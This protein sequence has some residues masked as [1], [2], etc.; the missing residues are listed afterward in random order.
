MA[1]SGQSP[2]RA[3]SRNSF[4]Q[5][6]YSVAEL[7]SV[8]FVMALLMS[9]VALIIGPLMRSQSQTQAKVDTVQAADVALYR[10][11][12]DL[13]NTNLSF[14]WSCT[15]TATPVCQAPPATL[16]T[17]SAIVVASAYKNGTGPFQLTSSTG[18]PKWQGATVYW[19]DTKGD[20]E[21]AFDPPS[22]FVPGS[23]MTIV[24]AQRAVSDVTVG[25]GMHLARFVE[26]LSLAVPGV[27]HQ[28]ALQMQ[29]QSTVNGAVN[30][31]T[32]RTDLETRN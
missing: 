25:G 26:T 5:R 7:L 1:A 28:V 22:G 11:E 17:T 21:V 13:R 2:S 29:A 15:T 31:T 4:T 19:V 18:K 32:Y 27:G 3:L 10:L 12:R 24:Q 23:N 30:E 14:I 9:A 20:L 6:G 8:I 16:S